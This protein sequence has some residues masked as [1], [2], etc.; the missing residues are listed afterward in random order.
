MLPSEASPS[1]GFDVVILAIP[2]SDVS[3]LTR[4]VELDPSTSFSLSLGDRIRTL[5]TTNARTGD[6][7]RGLLYVPELDS[8]N[9]CRQTTAPFIPANVTRLS[10]LSG[11]G[12]VI[13]IAPWISSTCTL[14]FLEAQSRDPP[15]AAVFY[16]PD[17]STTT[18][19]PADHPTWDLGDGDRWKNINR[20]PVY[21]IPGAYGTSVMRALSEY[22]GNLT[23]LPIGED[24]LRRFR[25]DELL[26]L[27]SKIAL[28]N[29]YKFTGGLPSLWIFLLAVVAIL[30]SV[31]FFSSI[32]MRVIQ[33]RQLQSLERRIA[34]GEV[35]LETLGIKRLNVPQNILDEMP[36]YI[37]HESGRVERLT[38]PTTEIA[39]DPTEE[40]SK[41]PLDKKNYFQSISN[42]R[43]IS[44]ASQ[45]LST[46]K[47]PVTSQRQSPPAAPDIEVSP[48]S[49]R[50]EITS[51]INGQ[52]QNA[53]PTFSQTTCPICLDDYDCGET[54]VRQLPCQHIFHPEC[55]DN[56][57]LQNSSLCPFCKM[58]VLPRGYCPEKITRGMV[59]RERLA[60]RIRLA[61]AA[62]T[63]EAGS[64]MTIPTPLGHGNHLPQGSAA[65]ERRSSF[66]N[67][68][69]DMLRH[70]R[71]SAQVPASPPPTGD[72]S[73]R[74]RQEELRLRAVAMLG[75]RPVIAN[76]E[77]TRNAS[78][79]KCKPQIQ[80]KLHDL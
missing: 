52:Q 74:Q 47:S 54:T 7:I 46:L 60:R 62:E 4:P 35:D 78:R 19:P 5:S 50:V 77:R 56:F 6:A 26:R 15:E 41:L 18:P 53:Q 66:R 68:V 32:A 39:P 25:G 73:S 61:Q 69:A 34:A 36:L 51:V 33:A 9:Q 12:K 8:G 57:L 10:D 45:V 64:G 29:Y 21:V 31:A 80:K 27:S 76:E 42:W 71:S 37:C 38:A 72:R 49:R 3:S 30:I 63:G 44:S 23:D 40:P 75:D 2:S 58:S 20:Y 14:S 24:V 67:S 70:S 11:I 65:A 16:L 1:N 55:I 48:C 13:S 59:R 43:W 22:S 17:V 28:G 79:S